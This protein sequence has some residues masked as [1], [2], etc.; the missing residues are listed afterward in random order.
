MLKFG[1]WLGTH[2]M[3]LTQVRCG[4]HLHVRTCTPLSHDG[5]S[6]VTRL[7]HRRSRRPTGSYSA[8]LDLYVTYPRKNIGEQLMFL[9]FFC[10]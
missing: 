6:A 8:L 1:A 7:V 10:K 3:S 4:A 5:A 9:V 2:S